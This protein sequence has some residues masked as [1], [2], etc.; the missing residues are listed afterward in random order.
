MSIKFTARESQTNQLILK[1]Y[2]NQKI[3]DELHV[4]INTV[5]THVSKVLQKAGA[6]NRIELITNFKS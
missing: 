4:S 6:K 5:K 1:G 2:S 3:A